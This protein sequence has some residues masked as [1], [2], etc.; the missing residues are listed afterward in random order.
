[1]DWELYCAR[2]KEEAF[3]ARLQGWRNDRRTHFASEDGT[4]IAFANSAGVHQFT[5]F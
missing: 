1:M 5:D 2:Y 3:Q 4:N